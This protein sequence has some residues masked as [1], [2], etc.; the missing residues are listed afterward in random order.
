MILGFYDY[1]SNIVCLMKIMGGCLSEGNETPLLCQ[2]S[3]QSAFFKGW[4][5][6]M[7]QKA[8]KGT[9]PCPGSLSSRCL[10]LCPCPGC[11]TGDTNP[12]VASGMV[13][14]MSSAGP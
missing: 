8:L 5:N 2:E 7:G 10:E 13:V 1:V 6:L 4:E 11:G 9:S 3:E 12:V 14:L